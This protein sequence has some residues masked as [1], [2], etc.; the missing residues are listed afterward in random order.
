MNDIDRLVSI[1]AIKHL[2]ACFIRVAAGCS[3]RVL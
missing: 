2:Q 1:E 3:K